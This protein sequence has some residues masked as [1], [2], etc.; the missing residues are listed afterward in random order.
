[1]RPP[2]PAHSTPVRGLGRDVA[3]REPAQHLVVSGLGVLV[4]LLAGQ[5]ACP[6]EQQ[7]GGELGRRPVPLPRVVLEPVS[8]EDAQVRRP[9]LTETG[10]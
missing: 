2:V 7:P 6:P 5:R 9:D 3:A 10:D 4:A 8:T 1:M